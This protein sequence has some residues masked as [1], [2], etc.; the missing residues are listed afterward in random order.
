[1]KIGIIGCGSMGRMFLERFIENKA[2]DQSDLFVSDMAYERITDLAG[3]YP[4]IN[5]C[6]SNIET[7]KNAQALFICL[8]PFDIKTALLEIKD[9][10]NENCIVVSL[11]GSVLFSQLE[12]IY[13]KRKVFKIMPSVMAE[14]NQSITLISGNDYVNDDDKSK[15]NKLLECFGKVIE[16]PEVEMGIGSE[17]TSCMPGFIS[18]IFKVITDEA[19]KHTSL[20]KEQIINMVTGTLFGT[21]KLLL[22]KNITFENLINR[23]AT[24]GGITEEGVKVINE[25]LPVIVTEIFAKTLENRNL[26]TDKA[27]ALFD[28]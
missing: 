21:A 10:I 13:P 17:L 22:E 8:K 6:K 2:A 11:N 20:S 14:V 18:A 19:E 3:V 26:T 28:S 16:I 9:S 5:I 1:M 4:Q 25:K 7:A 24:K 12:T 23:V 27:Q 15:L